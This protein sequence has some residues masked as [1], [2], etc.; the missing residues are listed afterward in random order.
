MPTPQQ[1]ERALDKVHD[2]SSFI[3][4]LLI[5]TLQWPIEPQVKA[6]EEISYDWSKEELKAHDLDR[7][8]V[9]GK[10]RQIALPNCPWGVFIVEFKNPDVFKSGRGMT[11]PLR[12]IL[13]GLVPRQKKSAQ[14]PSFFREHLLFICTHEYKYFRFVH[15]KD[16][17]ASFKQPPLASFGW[18]PG[19]STKT[20]CHYNLPHLKYL[21]E[22][23][24]VDDWLSEWS[25]AFDV[26]RV[27]KKFYEDYKQIHA[28]F[29][30]SIKGVAD[31]AD[32]T[33][34]A[35]VLLNRLMF[36]YFLQKK[37]FLDGGNESYLEQKLQESKPKDRFHSDFLTLLF[38]EGFAKPPEKR[39][40][41]AKAKLGNIRYLN[42]GLFIE[43]QIERKSREAGKT[44]SL[45]DSA[46]EQ[47]FKLFGSFSWNLNDK[48][49]G[50]DNEINPDVLGYI[51]EKY[52]N[53]KAFGAYY[54]RPE[55]TGYLCERTI[56][57][58]VLDAVNT[59]AQT[60]ESVKKAGLPV[61][62]FKSV[63]ELLGRLDAALATKLL[64][65][66]LPSLS[67]LDPACGPGAF[68]VAAMKALIDIYGW[69]EFNAPPALKTR[70]DAAGQIE[71][72]FHEL[73]APDPGTTSPPA[74]G[75]GDVCVVTAKPSPK[76][77]F[78]VENG[79]E[80]FY[81]RTGNASNA[82]KPSEMLTRIF[83]L[84]CE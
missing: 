49:G 44:I 28:L 13:S 10:I 31:T 7:R 80:L 66:V 59:P 46:F 37:G 18:W 36:V 57:R 25:T 62:S 27:T 11:T 39:S 68:L 84:I 5:D 79:Q 48:P 12:D 56:H 45:P 82:L 74:A 50:Q 54:T 2:E 1:I 38:F 75:S 73:K 9:D 41:A 34:L 77:R 76:P 24:T 4:D 60:I 30:D 71:I 67:L 17:G 69:I 53:Q 52:I 81:M 70:A 83:H 78:V 47:L 23:A 65:D 40:A 64:D 16:P 20:V 29:R 43:H 72:A 35:S 42:G 3:Q 8:V 58:L 6:V 33:W 26:E 19:D 21:D 63:A 14:L 61:R 55:I 15:F 32:R 22:K 51:V